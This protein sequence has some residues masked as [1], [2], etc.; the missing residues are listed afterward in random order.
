MIPGILWQTWKT[1]NI[2][3]SLVDQSN[4]WRNSNPQLKI[5]L[6]DDVMCSDFILQNFGEDVHR[7]YEALPQ[8]IMRAD[9]WRIAVVYVNGGYYSDLDITCNKNL[10]EFVNSK[11]K[12]VFMRELNNIANFFF[13]AEPKHPVLKLA[14]DYMI[15]EASIIIDKD[16]QSYGMHSLH[17][18]VREYY[19]VIETN[20]PNN[21]DVQILNNE[22]LKYNNILVHK[23][24]SITNKSTDY[25]SWRVNN[26][27]MQEKRKSACDILFFTTFND[28]GYE[29]YGKTWIETFIKISNYYP[30]IKAKI[31]YEGKQPQITHPNITYVNFANE[32]PQHEIWKDQLHKKSKHDD[33]VKTMIERFSYKSFVIQDVLSKHDDDYLIW[34]DGDCIFKTA[35]Y[36]DFPKNILEDKF[37]ACQIEEN[38]DL[39]HVESGIL[40]FNGKHHDIKKFNG[41]FIKNYTFEELLPM[42]QPYDGF[43]IF[44]T[45]LMTGVN[46]VN[47]NKD[48]GR[49]GIQSDPNCTFQHPELKSKFIHNIGWTGKHQYKNWEDIFKK[50]T[51]YNKVQTFLFGNSPMIA[52][53]RREI[54]DKKLNS[55]LNKR[56]KIKR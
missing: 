50:D 17:R 55:L 5:N 8:P 41:Q 28:N 22:E 16:T 27:I 31:Y 42:G 36:S 3:S 33:Y 24:A 44:R 4:S 48:Y 1:K 19:S 38:W 11:V 30:S 18:A 6:S 43:V 39:N 52:A 56:S 25:N 45:L 32:I 13:G 34:L 12:A 23:A 54:T 20:Y 26:T 40:I 37:L 10:N 2:P 9:F 14:L 46:Y 47:L 35:D 49:G 15:E 29:L 51:I 21:D 53:Q 7:L